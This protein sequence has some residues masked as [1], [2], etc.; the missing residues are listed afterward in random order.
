MYAYLCVRV[1]I[2]MIAGVKRD[3]W[4]GRESMSEGAER[5]RRRENV[6]EIGRKE[7]RVTDCIYMCSDTE[8]REGRVTERKSGRF[9]VCASVRIYVICMCM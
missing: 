5:A 9:N 7:S 8:R 4:I 3:G 6:T 1:C 2:C